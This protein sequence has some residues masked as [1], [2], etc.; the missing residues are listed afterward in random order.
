MMNKRI[1]FEKMLA[2][3]NNLSYE[4]LMVV[5]Y[6]SNIVRDMEKLL[7]LLDNQNNTEEVDMLKYKLRMML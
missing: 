6:T 4:Q 5:I 1:Y 2:D 7:D 3:S